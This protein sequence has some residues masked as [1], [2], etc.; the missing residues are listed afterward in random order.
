MRP[1][2]RRNIYG[3]STADR[4]LGVMFLGL[5][6]MAFILLSVMGMQRV[7]H[8]AQKATESV[9]E[10]VFQER[11]REPPSVESTALD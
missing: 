4:Y 5:A 1:H 11:D 9:S 8:S 2:P 6:V 3:E 7:E 10:S